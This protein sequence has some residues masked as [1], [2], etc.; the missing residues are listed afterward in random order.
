VKLLD[1]PRG[2]PA[3]MVIL[4]LGCSGQPATTPSGPGEASGAAPVLS[5]DLHSNCYRWPVG[6][7]TPRNEA[8]LTVGLAAGDTAVDFTLRDLDDRPVAL[9]SLLAEEPV[10]LILGSHT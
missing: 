4:L 7:F 9:S 10:L 2:V 1:G 3:L 8:A 5:A 6:Q